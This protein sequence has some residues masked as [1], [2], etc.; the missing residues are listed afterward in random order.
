MSGNDEAAIDRI[1]AWL[2][3][4]P[5]KTNLLC[6]E[7]VKSLANLIPNSSRLLLDHDNDKENL[8][9]GRSNSRIKKLKQ[10]ARSAGRLLSQHRNVVKSSKFD[11]PDVTSTS[12]IFGKD[13]T[14]H[15]VNAVKHLCQFILKNLE[16]EGIFRQNGNVTRRN[17]LKK[18]LDTGVCITVTDKD[19]IVPNEEKIGSSFN[20]HDAANVLKDLLR[21]L[22]KNIFEA[23][24]NI[25]PML[26]ED[27]ENNAQN[28]DTKVLQILF[29]FLPS[30]SR[31]VLVYVFELLASID[32]KSEVNKMTS[33]N[34]AL[35]F[36][37][38]LLAEGFIK[39]LTSLFQAKINITKSFTIQCGKFVYCQFI[40][41]LRKN[42]IPLAA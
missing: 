10:R 8:Q 25:I 5:E 24:P 17:K 37:P 19:D 40:K 3:T 14:S 35:V 12:L 18:A 30:K 4:D 38:I 11:E 42:S 1:Q 16:T 23:T 13:L 39:I 29:C 6:C 28:L 26:R 34:L 31:K 41:K 15:T 22:P 32:A 7:A 9:R 33:K 21:S 27:L 36:C 2:I 20:V